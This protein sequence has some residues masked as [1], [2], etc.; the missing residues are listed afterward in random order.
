M[1]ACP[2]TVTRIL[3]TAVLALALLSR[4]AA[5]EITIARIDIGLPNTA[6]MLVQGDYDGNEILRFK[7]AIAD[8]PPT[9]RIIAALNSPGGRVDQGF[10]LGKFFFDARIPTIVLAGHECASSCTNAFFG[11]RDPVT[12]QPL[13]ILAS[14]GKLGFHNFRSTNLPDVKYTKAQLEDLSRTTQQIVYAQLAYLKSVDAPIKAIVLSLGTPH[15]DVNWLSEADA[16][17]LGVT[18]LNREMGRL[19]TPANI[20][21]RTR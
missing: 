20:A 15:E 8:I 7:S 4:T 1:T 5:A 16:L 12:G 18:V 11:G 21:S 9:V 14:G 13:R 6:V 2:R 17:Q 3:Q 10:E 19:I